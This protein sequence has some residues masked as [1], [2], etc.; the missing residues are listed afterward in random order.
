MSQFVKDIDF[1]VVTIQKIGIQF[2]TSRQPSCK[3]KA[4]TCLSSVSLISDDSTFY[5]LVEHVMTCLEKGSNLETYVLLLGSL[6]RTTANRLVKYIGKIVTFMLSFIGNEDIDDEVKEYCFQTLETLLYKCPIDMTQYVGE[7]LEAS[8]K[9]I[10]Y[11]PNVAFE[12]DEE[13]EGDMDIEDDEEFSDDELGYS[14]EDDVSWKVRKAASRCITSVIRTRPELLSSICQQQAEVLIKRFQEREENVRLDV[15]A[16]FETLL[17]QASI[18]NN[19]DVIDT[20]VTLSPSIF[21]SV[22]KLLKEKSNKSLGRIGLFQ[23]MQHLLETLRNHPEC[24][25]PHI[26]AIVSYLNVS[27]DAKT[28][29]TQLKSETLSFL[30]KLLDVL[31]SNSF[32]NCI[33]E[34]AANVYKGVRDSHYKIVAESLV[35]CC[36]IVSVLTPSGD[37]EVEPSDT[38]KNVVVELFNVTQEKFKATDVDQEVKEAAIRVTSLLISKLSHIIPD[39]Q[40]PL[41][42]M[43]DRL[44]N[45]ITR[46]YA[47]RA[48]GEIALSDVDLS[49]VVI[50]ITKDLTS[51]LRQQSRPLKQSSISTLEV[52]MERYSPEVIPQL[53]ELH[54][55]I[56]K[57]LHN[58]VVGSELHL[59]HLSFNLCTILLKQKKK[60]AGP[61]AKNIL[62]LIYKLLSNTLLQGASLTSLLRLFK[63]MVE[64]HSKKLK[65]EVIAHALRNIVVERSS[66]MPLS[67]LA[68]NAIAQCIATV[69]VASPENLNASVQ[70]CLA[71]EEKEVEQILNIYTLGEIGRR[72]DIR[73]FDVHKVLLSQFDSPSEN[74]KTA[75][76][77]A[78]GCVASYDLSYYLSTIL[79]EMEN[80][81]K[82]QYLLIGSL[83]EII[84]TLSKDSEGINNI[85]PF[86]DQILK[87]LFSHCSSS[88][89]GTRNIVGECIGK[90]AL[91]Q[92]ETLIPVLKRMSQDKNMYTRSTIARSLKYA[93]VDTSDPELDALLST[94]VKSFLNLL[95]DSEIVVRHSSLLTFNHIVHH[96][97]Q[98]IRG[99][100]DE[101]FQTLYGET[102]KKPE[103]ITTVELGPFKHEVDNGQP[104]RQAAFECM[105]TLLDTCLAHLDIYQFI[106]HVK[107][108]LSDHYDIAT[109]NHLILQKVA[110]KAPVTLYTH[111]EMFIDPFKATLTAQVKENAPQH[112]KDRNEDLVRSALKSIMVLTKIQGVDE[113][114]AFNDFIKAT[115]YQNKELKLKFEAIHNEGIDSK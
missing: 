41:R 110:H 15:L 79:N 105:Y 59:S 9:F 7:I 29:T 92:Y 28:S 76:S 95:K 72:A 115:I 57:E 12:S 32:D 53:Q 78:L 64:V 18:S 100:L 86:V 58:L 66:E 36:G 17:K 22:I 112:E 4:I 90:I 34:L 85:A 109:L 87:H 49:S 10:K 101:Y 88:E 16:T 113:N 51:F 27:F 47:V 71:P 104:L 84:V 13:E 11:D 75:A 21:Q 45:E 108:G 1:E 74:V 93:I 6:C 55:D 44:K 35:V 63:T 94:E 54:A 52:L 33:S 80:Q 103:L 107:M 46:L 111:V 83:R 42:V 99:C 2:L 43:A 82:K 48:F 20:F 60:N 3:K 106:Q 68:Y 24:I 91:F 23:M 67:K 38:V 61:I 25:Q 37:M 65:P 5:A 73:K 40:E 96:K 26:P 81:P 50:D 19:S 89:E 56:I 70:S 98:L 39:V 14:D 62:P 8:D 102:V 114:Q 69:I 31:P 97:P 77:V 30:K